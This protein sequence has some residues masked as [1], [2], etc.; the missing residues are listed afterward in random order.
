M[1]EP[2]ELSRSSSSQEVLLWINTSEYC[3]D[4]VRALRAEGW[5]PVVR[6]YGNSVPIAEVSGVTIYG[7]DR[8]SEQLLAQ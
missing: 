8:I 7:M 5:V 2:N 6:S 4:L 3:I 1:M